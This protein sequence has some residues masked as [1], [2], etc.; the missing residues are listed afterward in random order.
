LTDIAV[1][2]AAELQG[3]RFSGHET[4]ACRYA[5]LP[6][7][8]RAL[9]RDPRTFSDED[10][11]MVEL[12]LGKNMVRAL[13]FW[14]EAM[15]VAA[16]DKA[17]RGLV[18]TPFGEAIFGDGGH[19]PFLEH[20][21]TLWLLHWN[22]T[23]R[24]VGALFAWRFMFGHWPYP[25]F[26][27]SEVL[28]EFRR[29]SERQGLEHSDVTL[30]QHLDVFL[31]TYHPSRANAGIEDSLDGPLVD[32]NLMLTVGERRQD[33]ARWETVYGF[34]REPKPEIGQALFDYCLHDFWDRFE[35]GATLGFRALAMAAAS[36][37]QVFKLTETDLH[38]RLEEAPRG[39]RPRGFTYQPSAIQGLLFRTAESATE[40]PTL[41]DVYAEPN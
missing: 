15:G 21:R 11:A 41:D 40:R 27:R 28:K 17:T 35:S 18:L 29:V 31:H 26:S 20:D 22:L 38:D 5:W 14:V 32:L 36:P 30:A 39:G 16:S 25:E 33:G 24:D 19:D 13:R 12:G 7:A 2:D 23:S 34:R 4:F 9:K 37:G 1:F 3:L 6:K 8:V 10:A